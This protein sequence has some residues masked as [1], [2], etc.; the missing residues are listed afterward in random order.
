[1]P[2]LLCL[3]FEGLVFQGVGF[4]AEPARLSGSRPTKALATAP[5]ASA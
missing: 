1:M 3:R 4:P 2:P 5:K